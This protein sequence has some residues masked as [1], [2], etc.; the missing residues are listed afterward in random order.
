M[1]PQDQD[2]NEPEPKRQRVA[3]EDGNKLENTIKSI[4]RFLSS[5][6][7]RDYC[8][9]EEELMPLILSKSK[10]FKEGKSLNLASQNK[11][12]MPELSFYSR[13]F[14]D[15]EYLKINSGSVDKVIIL[16]F[17][18]NL[19]KLKNLHILIKNEDM[20]NTT[21]IYLELKKV[22]IEVSTQSPIL[23]SD[24]VGQILSCN[25][26]DL[27]CFTLKG[28]KLSEYSINRLKDCKLKSISLHDVTIDNFYI[29]EKLNNYLREN[30]NFEKIK[31]ISKEDRNKNPFFRA[32]ALDFLKMFNETQDNLK[33]LTITLNQE[34]PVIYNLTRFIKLKKFTFYYCPLLKIENVIRL[35][36]QINALHNI[37]VFIDLEITAIQSYSYPPALLSDE[38]IKEQ[39]RLFTRVMLSINP[40]L[41]IKINDIE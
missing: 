20:F 34:G 29:K 31:I 36:G 37:G 19:R 24:P 30:K 41:K 7:N 8:K 16:G 38:F 15:L 23:K 28:G 21:G 4:V 11:L 27:E 13:I 26:Q 25:N 35:L 39:S 6:E 2:F 18:S 17:I 9:I 22:K 32:M 10:T 14:R 5:E 40:K 12:E 3:N 33:N 1:N